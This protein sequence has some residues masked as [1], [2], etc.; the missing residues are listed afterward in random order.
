MLSL[1][2]SAYIGSYD[3]PECVCSVYRDSKTSLSALVAKEY[4]L[5]L[6]MSVY[7]GSYESPECVCSV[8][9]RH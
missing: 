1:S 2:K 8:Y 6:S 3:N 4:M 5:S 9:S 7:I